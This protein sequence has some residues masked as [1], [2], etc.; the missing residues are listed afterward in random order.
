MALARTPHPSALGI[1]PGDLWV[2]GY[3]SLMWDPGFPFRN[4]APALVFGYH[5]A[6]CITSSRWRGTPERPGLVL[7]LVRGG[8]CRG[9]AFRVAQRDV[10]ATLD[11]LWAREMRRRVYR[12]RMLR[13]RLPDREVRAL[14]F[15]A[16]PGHDGY[17]GPLSVREKAKRI[18]NCRGARGPNLDYLVR[19]INHLAELGMRD[20]NLLRVLAAVKALPAVHSAA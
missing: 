10:T 8:A 19:T 5:R 3:G 17:A 1:P 4:W 11:A 2:F 16:D 15:T 20:D 9:I 13:A 12:P 18:A 7:G 6:L 14:A